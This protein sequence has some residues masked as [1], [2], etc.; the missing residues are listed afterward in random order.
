MEAFSTSVLT[1]TLA[2]VG[3]KTQLLS[4]LLALRFRNKWG[5]IL[6]I[7]VATLFNHAVS[8]W[9]GSWIGQYFQSQAGQWVIGGSFILLG[10]WLL[11]PDKAEGEKAALEHYGAFIASTILFFIAEIGDKTQVATV[12]LGAQF[13]ALVWVTLGTTLGM[14]IA[15]IPVVFAGEYLMRRIPLRLTRIVAATVFVLIGLIQLVGS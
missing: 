14:L 5:I 4:L 2:E 9:L 11:I 6:G 10:L 3:D 8:A 15:N 13:N 12:L 7:T 1:V